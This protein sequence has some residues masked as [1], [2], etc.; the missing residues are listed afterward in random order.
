[1]KQNVTRIGTS[2]A[3]AGLAIVLMMPLLLGCDSIFGSGDCTLV[4][5]SDGVRVQFS[6]M[7]PDE[8]EIGLTPPGGEERVIS[9]APAGGGRCVFGA[10]FE[11][12]TATEAVLHVRW[13]QGTITQAV[14]LEY[15]RLRPNGPRCDP[16]C[17]ITEV[18]V[19]F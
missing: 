7:V 6:G 18:Q 1:M 4:D 17:L 19:E 14:Q 10:F 3:L 2:S 9:C 11:N 12:M 15:D 16:V 5:C 8:F 13:E